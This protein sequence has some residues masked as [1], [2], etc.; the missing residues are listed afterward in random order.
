MWHVVQSQRMERLV[1]AFFRALRGSSEPMVFSMG[2]VPGGAPCAEVPP[3]FS[4]KAPLFESKNPPPEDPFTPEVVVVQDMGMARWITHQL[5][6]HFG[7]AANFRFFSPAGLV[8]LVY[9]AW[10]GE[11]SPEAAREAW[12]RPVLAWRLFRLLDHCRPDSRFQEL[13]H[14][15]ADDPSGRKRYEL[16][17]R[18]AAVFDRY[19]VYRQ[20][21][22]LSWENGKGDDW[23]AHLWRLL[24]REIPAPHPVRRHEAFR[25]AARCGY[26]PRYPT[27]LPNRVTLFGVA[28]MAPV[29]FEVFD[30]LASRIPVTLYYL[31]PSQEYWGDA[32][33]G[34]E[35]ATNP[36][37]ASWA[38]AGR[39]LFERIQNIDGFHRDCF[40]DLQP[41]TLLRAVQQDIHTLMDRRTLIAE[42]RLPVADVDSIQIHACH[43]PMREVQVLHDRIAHFLEIL[44]GLTPE[45]IVVMAPDI[46]TYAPYVEAVFGTRDNP[47]LPW[48]LSE[49]KS[50]EDDPLMEKILDLLR[51]PQWRCSA[52]DILALLETPP[53]AAAY[54][55]DEKGLDRVHAWV[56]ESGIRWGLDDAMRRELNLPGERNH[57]WRMGLDR[58]LAGY[59]LPPHELFWEGIL[60]YPHV[61]AGDG[62]WLGALHDLLETV[63]AWRRIL[64]NPKTPTAWRDECNALV[65]SFFMRTPRPSHRAAVHPKEETF[66]LIRPTGL[67]PN[68]PT[69][70][71]TLSRFRNAL[72]A[73]CRSAERAGC[74]EPVSIEVIRESLRDA[75]AESP[76]IRRFLSGGVTFCNLVP[77]R[78][79]PFRVVWLLGMNDADFPRTERF[80]QFDLMTKEQRSGDRRRRWEDRYLFLEALLS[81]RDVFCVSYVGRD[82]RD[83]SQRVPSVVV[84]EL[85]DYLEEIYRP[86]A[87]TGTNDNTSDPLG[88]G[89]RSEQQLFRPSPP[90]TH[91]STPID[92][93]GDCSEPQHS[94]PCPTPPHESK[95]NDFP[96]SETLRSG[97]VVEHPLQ[98]F[99]RRLFDDSDPRLFSYDDQWLRAAQ[100]SEGL[101]LP[102]FMP[103]EASLSPT[104]VGEIALEELIRF[105][106]NPSAYFLEKA[107]GLAVLRQEEV[108]EKEEPFVL[109]A[110]N[111][112]GLISEMVDALLRGEG[113][114][115]LRRRIRARGGLPHG[116]AGNVIFE[117][118]FQAA[119]ELAQKIRS[120]M[121][122]TPR[123]VE[124]DIALRGVRLYGWLD[125]VTERGRLTYRPA[126]IKAKHRLRL[127]ICHLALCVSRPEGVSP[128]SVHIGAGKED[129]FQLEL[130]EEPEKHLQGL[131]ELFLDGQ[132]R[133]LP[134]FPESS[135][136]YAEKCKGTPTKDPPVRLCGTAWKN[137]Y[138]ELG[139]AYD[140]AVRTAFRGI[141]PLDQTFADIACRVFGP[142]LPKA[143]KQPRE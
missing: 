70:E 3:E 43:S 85:L 74:S 2:P 15:M 131:I 44:P 18:I 23:Q 79:I 9:E 71:E 42:N 132:R 105:F 77:M 80:P 99:S 109:D 35:D 32:R 58:L 41:D 113:P 107:L 13:H 65:D 122:S 45:D 101:T 56:R 62:P 118:A 29:H 139:D 93:W 104:D 38:H 50:P 92:G 141:D 129:V 67:V 72:D 75:L 89:M 83:N 24:V 30:V 73:V 106:E 55:F 61:E 47:R 66:D 81:A 12:S 138:R 90:S 97:I 51:L 120:H 5:A 78:A 140:A 4:E 34:L 137:E 28:M 17:A 14:Y 87:A 60:A 142:I 124:V 94:P 114:Q 48:N 98:P 88:W 123:F 121:G 54:G 52:T 95:N 37:M 1:E 64:K 126:Q 6:R 31:N 40:D 57:T 76:N 127:W 27:R 102:P 16:A 10:L 110:L 143:E 82:I 128:V 115:E 84:S 134:F 59:A 22:L 36:L 8:D 63:E 11:E 116:A 133:P 69:E 46:D 33:P 49:R 53:V 96:T 20:D 111:R 19:L 25:N 103:P 100:T 39:D 117:D 119:C 26:G 7:I 68:D 91:E 136:V 108:L 130:I 86:R 135:W 125:R 21:V 112:Y